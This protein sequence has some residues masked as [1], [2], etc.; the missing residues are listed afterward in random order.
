MSRFWLEA[1]R[2]DQG[3]DHHLFAGHGADVMVHTQ[4]LHAGGFMDQRLQHGAGQLQQLIPCLLDEVP[5]FIRR[6]GLGELSFGERQNVEYA[7]QQEVFD[8]VRLNLFRPPSQIL[9]LK[10]NDSIADDGFAF[11]LRQRV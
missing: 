3:K 5:A 11:G 10:A 1:R 6:Q 4:H 2:C 7:D 8:E 9:F